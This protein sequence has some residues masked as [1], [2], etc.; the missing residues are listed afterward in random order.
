MNI[1]GS[2]S[3]PQYQQCNISIV[4]SNEAGSS[5]PFILAFGKYS[6]NACIIYHYYIDTTP[7]I[8]PTSSPTNGTDGTATSSPDPIITILGLPLHIT[9]LTYSFI[10][11]IEIIIVITVTV[12]VVLT[13]IITVVV[14]NVKKGKS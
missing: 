12:L 5:E 1:T 6:V 11:F 2:V 9:A 3:V 13:I 10:V 8:S 7:P 14:V 4:F